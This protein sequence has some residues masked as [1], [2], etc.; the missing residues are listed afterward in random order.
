M[1]MARGTAAG[2]E[3]RRWGRCWAQ[4]RGEPDFL[5][6]AG[7]SSQL[8]ASIQ[9]GRSWA[10]HPVWWHARTNT[11]SAQPRE[12]S[13]DDQEVERVTPSV[14]WEVGAAKCCAAKCCPPPQVDCSGQGECR[15]QS[16]AVT[17]H[18]CLTAVH[19]WTAADVAKHAML[20]AISSHADG[21]EERVEDDHEEVDG[22]G[23]SDHLS[24][25]SVCDPD[26]ARRVDEALRKSLQAEH[27]PRSEQPGD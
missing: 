14:G 18:G 24:K 26:C 25:L 23:I 13:G 17:H 9:D 19:G 21:A 11:Q 27:L 2:G 15:L 20:V 12:A 7:Q 6:R 5:T 10:Q 1:A 3:C 4:R 16:A 8:E 22:H